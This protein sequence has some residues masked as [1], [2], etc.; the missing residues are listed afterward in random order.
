MQDTRKG[1][2]ASDLARFF[3]QVELRCKL[4]IQQLMED[5][6]VQSEAPDFEPIEKQLN[7]FESHIDDI[8]FI[9]LKASLRALSLAF[10]Q[11]GKD[12]E[13]ARTNGMKRLEAANKRIEHCRQWLAC[14]AEEN[15][16]QSLYRRSE[17]T[18]REAVRNWKSKAGDF[19]S[20]S[21]ETDQEQDEI[22]LR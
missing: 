4:L 5:L 19:P 16:Q 2:L 18:G 10:C 15:W 11:L 14:L 17:A 8:S 3:I 12:S 9:E 7:E 22:F 6:P 20:A 1:Q 21:E 13:C